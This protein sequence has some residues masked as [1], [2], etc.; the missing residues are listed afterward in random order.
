MFLAELEKIFLT[1]L[2]QRKFRYQNPKRFS[3]VENSVGLLV[4]FSD[5]E[6]I[7]NYGYDDV[8]EDEPDDFCE[9]L[10]AS[11][12][13]LGFVFGVELQVE[14]RDLEHIHAVQVIFHSQILVSFHFN[15]VLHHQF[16]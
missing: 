5:V 12:D 10:L 11:E 15:K 1:K 6:M 9:D 13:D 8:V 2:E 7:L 14:P 16:Q 3:I 4:L